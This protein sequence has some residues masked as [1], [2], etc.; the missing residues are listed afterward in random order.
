MGH[1]FGFNR[2]EQDEDYIRL[3]DL[4]RM[5]VDIVSKNGNLLLNVGPMADGTIP[6]VQVDLLRGVGAWLATYGEAI[7]GTRPWERAEGATT[8]GGRVRFTR[9]ASAEGETIYALFLDG[10]GEPTVTI[11]DLRVEEGA[12]A[13]DVATGRAVEMRRQGGDLTLIVGDRA[14]GADV[15]AVAITGSGLGGSA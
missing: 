13:R 1:G 6:P 9:R 12:T 4:I 15:R 7:Y 8:S 11:R 3:P 5:L 10:L 2:E 14:S